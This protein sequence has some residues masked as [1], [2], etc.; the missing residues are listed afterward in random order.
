L[1]SIDT[2]RAQSSTLTAYPPQLVFNGALAPAQPLQITNSTGAVNF[3]VQAFS[4][5]NWLVVSP[6][7][8]VTPATLSVSVGPTAPTSGS[9]VGFINISS[10][11]GQFQS[12]SVQFN[13]SPAG[14]PSPLS[15]N[16]TSLSFNFA[17]NSTVPVTQ[18]VGVSSSSGTT[19]FSA[20]A[21]TNNSGNWL[22]VSPSSGS[23]PSTLMVTVN[24]AALQ[25]GGSFSGAIAVNAPGSNGVS[26]PVLVTVAGT[27]AVNASPTQ[28]SF[29]YQIGTSQPLAQN[30][31]ITSSTGANVS[32]SASAKTS[33]C[34]NN[35]L[36]L[37]Q[38]S[39]ATPSTLSVQV[40]VS[41]LSAG[42][43]T[44]EIDIS[45]P[46]AS[47][48]SLVVPVNLLVST[49]PLLQVP[50]TGPT[51][52]YQVGSSV[53]PAA[54]NVQITSS[55]SGVSFTA[56]ASAPSGSP[57]FLVVSPASGTTPQ[58]LALS[59]NASA[60]ANVGPGTYTETVTITASGAGNSP[61]AFPVTLIVNSNPVLTSTVPSLNFNYQIGQ[62]APSSQTITINSTGA[63]LNYQV[64]VNASS[65]AGFLAATPTT[66][67]TFSPPPQSQNQVVVS[68]NTTGLTT[69]Q[70][71]SGNVTLT[72]P[73]SSTPP[74]VT[75][76][77]LN[78]SNTALLNVGQN[79][80]NLTVLAGAS[81]TTQT[82]SVSSTDPNNQLPF[83]AVAS[84]NPVG[85]TWL[86]V[87]PNSGNTPNNLQVTI[88]PANLGPGTYT[89]SIIVSSSAANV[90]AQT[91]P[92]TLVVASSTVSAT[93]AS[94]TFTQSIGGS[95]PASQM[96]TIAG[97]PAGTTIG[98]LTT[99]LN[100][101]GWLT[102]SVSGNTVT[103]NAN[104]SPLPQGAYQGV[105]TVIVPGAGNSPLYIPVTLSVG[106][107]P[108]L[109]VTPTTVNFT[110]VSGSAA[111]PAAQTVQVTSNGS[112]TFNASFAPAASI[113][114]RGNFITVTPA[115]G[116]A[117]AALTL[118]VNGSIV[119]TLPP[120]A[121][122]G[123]VTVSSPNIASQTI[124]VTLTV[125]AAPP[126]V[127]I[128]IT[129]A[130]SIQAGPISPGEVVSIFGSNVGPATPPG[131]VLFSLTPSGMVPTTLGGVTVTFNG[132]AAPLL[133]VNALQI[134]AI[135]PYEIAGQTSA[136]VVVMFGG[137]NSAQ[138]Q[139][140]VVDTR[141]AIFS[142]S[143]GGSGQGAILNQDY[144]VNGTNK[145]AAKG[146]V[147]Q[148][149]GTG[150]GQLVPAVLTGS[151]TPGVAPFPKPVAS[152]ITVTIGGQ[153]AQIQYAGEAP[154]LV[155]GVFQI[156]AVVPASIASGNQPLVV[157]IGSNTNNTQSITVAVQ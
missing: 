134:N 10:S 30:L 31:L 53:L 43:C 50:S 75:P 2:A 63:P 137:S 149:F 157:T 110:Y 78:V 132:V 88:N 46:S 56:A 16:P 49:N 55:T 145:P 119:P 61:Q 117:P 25:G 9:D 20:S 29:G 135:V 48:P 69:P 124:N 150:E 1:C 15:A 54:Q 90:P 32:F 82:V 21:I 59:L 60:L 156:N 41:S 4:N 136:N 144:S 12:V 24:P 115:S 146:S 155:S 6:T 126:P 42:T 91:I 33:T 27:P 62:T 5:N 36:V 94:L 107:A 108:T 40:N 58:A 105:V 65:C 80:I 104:G 148:I 35:W 87:V 19:S 34:G 152:N 73:G 98:A 13:A 129:N 118:A 11:S 37:S 86:S 74:L 7:N 127:I 77:T 154:T 140:S 26:I 45:A 109:S 130:A 52:N 153:P 47:N 113:A 112:V 125:S 101:T 106:P 22:T 121:Y 8:G 93:P 66:G 28:L 38:Q 51:F 111:L 39:G 3:T 72:V 122:S 57:N 133:F 123:T 143:Q 151:V 95:Q 142:L 64:A 89:G 114:N 44:G 68:V 79:V 85:L 83:T 103:V 99:M 97:V 120:G 139:T 131:G 84:T 71:C 141:P 102:A 116:T 96:I 100:G 128:A 14:G 147:I 92:I 81:A 138:L 17:A 70:V 67:S 23:L 76:V 18:N